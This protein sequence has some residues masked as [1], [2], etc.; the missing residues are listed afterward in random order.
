MADWGKM[1]VALNS[2]WYLPAAGG[3]LRRPYL[4]WPGDVRAVGSLAFLPRACEGLPARRSCR[5]NA[6]AQC[7]TAETA[8]LNTSETKELFTWVVGFSG[9]LHRGWGGAP[10]QKKDYS[11]MSRFSYLNVLNT[12]MGVFCFLNL[13]QKYC[14]RF[15]CSCWIVAIFNS[16]GCEWKCEYFYVPS[17]FL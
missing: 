13:C 9:A 6:P 3:A 4:G 8:Y 12:L 16:T 7:V 10:P 5:A 14:I 15:C 11:C 2:W 17:R 1:S